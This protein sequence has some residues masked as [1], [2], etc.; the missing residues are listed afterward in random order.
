MSSIPRR[1]SRFVFAGFLSM[2]ISANAA[3]NF[4]CEGKIHYLGLGPDGNVT[5]DVGFGAWYICNLTS[6]FLG[7][8]GIT[9]TPEGCRG[10][11]ASILASQKAEDSIVFFFQSSASTGNGAEC[12]MGSWLTPN[13]SPY[14]MTV[15]N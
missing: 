15:R 14:H 9:F 5:V 10:W 11:Y 7:N 8:G 12:S 13:P 1:A 2:L 6:S 4:T 3:A